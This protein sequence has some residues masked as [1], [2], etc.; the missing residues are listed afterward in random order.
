MVYAHEKG[1]K[2]CDKIGLS[3][4]T[5]KRFSQQ[6]IN[7]G[8][9][10]PMGKHYQFIDLSKIMYLL[11]E[12]S[13]KEE[14]WLQNNVRFFTGVKYDNIKYKSVLS[15]IEFAFVELNYKQQAYFNRIKNRAKEIFT[16]RFTCKKDYQFL[17]RAVSLLKLPDMTE[18]ESIVNENFN[19]ILTGK[20]H[21]ANHLG[22][23]PST[24]RNRLRE[25]DGLYI[26]RTIV[27]EF[28]HCH[29]SDALFDRLKQ[30]NK[31]VLPCNNGFLLSKGSVITPYYPIQ[32][33][34][35]KS[36][37]LMYDLLMAVYEMSPTLKQE[38]YSPS[39][40]SIRGKF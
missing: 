36:G 39:L 4:N 1:Y 8:F 2:F 3:V 25:W 21:V 12:I 29:T 11:F 40:A 13:T 27:S 10:I 17:K 18:L 33:Q 16:N 22:T 14:K 38:A 26:S 30:S 15:R 35:R 19:H 32:P 24:G 23:S 6:A 31:Y 7:D 34:V 37:S 5:Y 9:L 20:Y 28:V